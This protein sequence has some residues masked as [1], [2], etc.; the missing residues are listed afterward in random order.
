[1]KFL[2][3]CMACVAAASCASP[4]AQPPGMPLD[5]EFSHGEENSAITKVTQ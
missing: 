1:M 4:P 3:L 5:R 2:F